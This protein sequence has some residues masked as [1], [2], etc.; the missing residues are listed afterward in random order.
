MK[1]AIFHPEGNINNNPNL[2]GIVEILCE[3][4]YEVDIYSKYREN[5]YQFSPCEGA[6]L[7]LEKP[8]ELN[9]LAEIIVRKILTSYNMVI[10]VDLGIIEASE[11]SKIRDIPLAY[12]SYE[13]FFADEV[14]KESKKIEIDAC[15][16][17]RFAIIQDEI[18]GLK[19]TVEN[20]I[21]SDK[22]IYIPV[23]GRKEK[24][25]EKSMFLHN[26]LGIDIKKKIALVMGSTEKWTQ[27]EDLIRSVPS[28]PKDWVLVLHNRYGIDAMS[29]EIKELIYKN[30]ESV[31]ISKDPFSKFEDL[32]PLIHS[33]SV[34]IALYK[35][36]YESK[37]T[38]KNVEF[39]GLAS[40]KVSSYL[41]HGLPLITI[42]IEPLNTLVSK[43]NAGYTISKIDEISK[44]LER[45]NLSQHDNALSLFKDV[46]NLELYSEI[47][48][49]KIEENIK[50]DN[51]NAF[52]NEKIQKIINELQIRI[53]SPLLEDKEKLQRENNFIL[54][55]KSYF[56]GTLL[57]LPYHKMKKF[58]T[59]QKT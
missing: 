26:R 29:W 30:S 53:F 7:F 43:Y 44:V 20:K 38:G 16:N 3:S 18:R 25:Y 15:K 55:S 40:G 37:Y 39:M 13:I 59:S 12:I 14:G 11:I 34:G 50:K 4:G 47:L 32:T 45:I 10:G 57:L 1:I 42:E 51:E 23:A 41:Q 36:T 24:V 58:F 31:F 35:A 2:N 21:S 28:W 27:T 46:F 54:N 49:Q 9:Q 6:N 5:V 33:A 19:L 56:L 8:N 48:I 52:L 22:L 17:I